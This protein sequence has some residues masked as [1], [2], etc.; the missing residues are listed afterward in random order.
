MLFVSI[1]GPHIL[2]VIRDVRGHFGSSNRE[3]TVT[4]LHRKNKSQSAYL[5]NL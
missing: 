1:R 2:Y 5:S 4:R 3:P